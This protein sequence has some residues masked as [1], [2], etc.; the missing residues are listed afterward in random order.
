MIEAYLW[1]VDSV[2]RQFGYDCPVAAH[3]DDLLNAYL[4]RHGMEYVRTERLG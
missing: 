1:F 4:K 3:M 2:M